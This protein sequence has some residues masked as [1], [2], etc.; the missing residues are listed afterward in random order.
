VFQ[1]DVGDP[2]NRIPTTFVLKATLFPANMR[3]L[4]LTGDRPADLG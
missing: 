4:D 2:G 1:P 3:A